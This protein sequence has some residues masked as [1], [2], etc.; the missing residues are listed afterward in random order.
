MSNRC[1]LVVLEMLYRMKKKF[2]KLPYYCEMRPKTKKWGH[3]S[4]ADCIVDNLTG[5]NNNFVFKFQEKD[6]SCYEEFL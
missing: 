2:E 6:M 4:G 5:I 1:I 3:T